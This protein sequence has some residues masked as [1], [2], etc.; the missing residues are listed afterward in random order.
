[1][2]RNAFKDLRLNVLAT[3]VWALQR[4]IEIMD[5]GSLILSEE[6]AGEAGRCLKL[7]VRCFGWLALYSA[8]HG[9]SFFK[10]RPKSHYLLHVASQ[11]ELWRINQKLF[12][13]MEEES[14][15][16]KLK[17][18]AC[19]AHGRTLSQR[20]IQRYLLCLALFVEQS[21]RRSL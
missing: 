2:R 19:K 21:R 6:D 1:M 14:F 13:T 9:E 16:G 4:T 11:L 8:D 20:I 3:C 18:I 10:V 12:H 17:A 7:H 15:L 5:A